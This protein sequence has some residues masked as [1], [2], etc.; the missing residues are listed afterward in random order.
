MSGKGEGD[1]KDLGVNQ[2]KGEE[3]QGRETMKNK[4]GKVR[5]RM[6]A[7]REVKKYQSSMDLFIRRLPFQCVVQ[8]IT[9]SIITD[10]R[11]QSTAIMALQEAREAF[12]VGLL[13]QANLCVVHVRRVTIMPKDV[14]LA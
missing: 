2:G 8:E 3:K 12:L 13:E 4:M 1:R 7:L 9:Q 10:L 14:Q 11:Y 5:R 6:K